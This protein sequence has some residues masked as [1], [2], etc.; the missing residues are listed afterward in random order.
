MRMIGAALTAAVLM[1]GVAA[2]A[3]GVRHVPA[4]PG[5]PFSAATEVNGVLYLSGQ[6]GTGPDGKLVEG[7]EAQT[8]QMMDNLGA[9]LKAQGLGWDHVFKCTVMLDDM[10]QWPAFNAIYTT[11][12][13]ADRLP[14]RSAFGADGLALGAAVEL[15]C[16]AAAK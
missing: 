7:F 1:A 12:F 15:E 9:T 11:Y 6:L 8:R 13:K 10:G 4:R 2:E 5:A 16:L 14:A 3:Q